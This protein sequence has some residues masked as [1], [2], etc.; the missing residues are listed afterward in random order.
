M[1]ASAA[2]PP[3]LA[4]VPVH[5][6]ANFGNAESKLNRNATAAVAKLHAVP[7]ADPLRQTQMTVC[8]LHATS[9]H[10]LPLRL[11]F[12]FAMDISIA[13]KNH[14]PCGRLSILASLL[15]LQMRANYRELHA[16]QPINPWDAVRR[17]DQPRP[18]G[19]RA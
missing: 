12:D 19:R 9:S 17:S 8:L 14:A 10:P 3:N 1:V 11:E 2:T 7:Y 5:F 13:D 6:A 16:R 15:F 18:A 4:A